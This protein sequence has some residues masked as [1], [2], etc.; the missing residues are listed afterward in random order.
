MNIPYSTITDWASNTCKLITPLYDALKKEV[1]ASDYLHVD[2]SPI[3][4]WTE[5]KKEKHT[6]VTIGF[7]I[8]A[9]KKWCSSIPP[10]E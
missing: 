8:T 4:Y 1:L 3:K 7:I 2:E 5:I 9:S 6:A 10:R